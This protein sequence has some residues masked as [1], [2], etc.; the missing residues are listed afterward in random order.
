MDYNKYSIDW[1]DKI[2][3]SIL[4]RDNYKC[5]NCGISHRAVGYFDAS[6]KFIECDNFMQEWAKRNKIK[7]QTIYLQVAH[8]DQNPDNNEESNLKSLCPRCHLA[9]D[10]IYNIAKRATNRGT[11]RTG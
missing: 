8:L 2:R 5:K 9:Y 1:R 4:K 7:L 11:H 10:R 6:K 3:P